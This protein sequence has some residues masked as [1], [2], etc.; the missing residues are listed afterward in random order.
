MKLLTLFGRGIL[1]GLAEG[2]DGAR[3]RAHES[4]GFVRE[5]KDFN[6]GYNRKLNEINDFD[7]PLQVL[8][9][10]RE[11][12][13]VVPPKVVRDCGRG[14]EV[15]RRE[16]L[17]RLDAFGTEEELSLGE[18]RE[19]ARSLAEHELPLAQCSQR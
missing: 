5:V 1:G 8:P 10:G 12:T 6:V 18:A 13:R 7:S 15:L 11:Q 9:R 19:L 16:L 14:V 4:L 2:H 17:R 3:L